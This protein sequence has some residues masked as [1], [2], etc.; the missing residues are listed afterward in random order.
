MEMYDFCFL[1]LPHL[2]IRS[3]NLAAL[4][5]ALFVLIPSPAKRFCRS[6]F[7]WAFDEYVILTGSWES[8]PDVT[9]LP[10]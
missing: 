5:V 4:E 1:A 2:T 9:A 3:N 7:I 6:D 10:I 8:L